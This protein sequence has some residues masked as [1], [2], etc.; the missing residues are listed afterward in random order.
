MSTIDDAYTIAAANICDEVVAISSGNVATVGGVTH[1][2]VNANQ[3]VLTCTNNLK[4]GTEVTLSGFTIQSGHDAT[5]LNGLTVTV[6]VATPTSF[7]FALTYANYDHDNTGTV[8]VPTSQAAYTC[9]GVVDAGQPRGQVLN[10][11][12]SSMAGYCVPPGDMWRI[13]AGA[14]VTPTL[15]LTQDDLRGP[16]K[17]DVLTTK[18]DLANGIQG[19]IVCP[20]NNWQQSTYPP[21]IDTA[22]FAQDGNQHIW[23]NLDL[24]YTTD[25]IRA[26][27]LAKIHLERIRRQKKLVLS[28]KLSAFPLQPGDAVMFTF[29]PLG[30]NQKIFEV[31][32]A[33][34]VQD[35]TGQEA[36]YGVGEEN[37]SISKVPKIPAL[38]ID[39]VLKEYDSGI[40]SWN[41]ATDEQTWL[42]P[43]VPT[44][45]PSLLTCS[46]VTGVT[47]S[48]G[49]GTA[50]VRADGLI[51]DRLL[52]QWTS[53]VDAYV[54]NGGSIEIYTSPHGAG[55]WTLAGIAD[56]A[57]TQF[58]VLNVVD[59]SSYDVQV[60]AVNAAGVTSPGVEVDGTVASGGTTNFGGSI[61]SVAA[62]AVAT[63]A[64][65]A[66]TAIDSGGVVV[67]GSIDLSRAY[68]NKTLDNIA[69]GSSYARLTASAVASSLLKAAHISQQALGLRTTGQTVVSGSVTPFYM[70]QWYLAATATINVPAGTSSIT[71]IA[72]VG[73]GGSGTIQGSNIGF[74]IYSGSAPSS[75]Q[76]AMGS[77]TG[78]ALT[79][80]SPTTGT[81]LTLGL[82]LMATTGGTGQSV[83]GTLSQATTTPFAAG[84]IT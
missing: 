33:A 37:S 54:V 39:L 71:L 53:P 41:P 76:V 38:G 56:G 3:C 13:Y 10:T 5:F 60:Y 8:T 78:G 74:A 69:D 32:Q 48:S 75:P 1:V 15:I 58:Y 49:A 81:G 43:A 7:T 2:N 9:D 27:R 67:A 50:I 31:Q 25:G 63:G 51:Q 26:Q 77:W 24:P 73:Q 62:S 82:F 35:S 65:L 66:N 16:I 40:F 64:S 52:V 4:M 46:P 6:L 68:T 34:I 45:M 47:V 83:N 28:C 29:A 21:Y 79:L 12:L 55:T 11:L 70:N 19:T 30:F 22:A 44:T 14:Y 84:S 42:A 18:R 57:D 80:S 36:F 17:M 20:A 23:Q 72:S 61:A 59:G